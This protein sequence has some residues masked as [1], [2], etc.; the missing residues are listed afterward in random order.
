[1]MPEALLSIKNVVATFKLN[2]KIDVGKVHKAFKKESTCNK[3]VF[4]KKVVVLKV[5]R[6]RMSFLIY[7]T[8]SVVC[9]GAES[10]KDAK[11]S[12]N[13]LAKRF[14]KIGINVKL[15]TPVEIQNIVAS[16]NLDT[17]INLRKI[18]IENT[19]I[20][21]EPEQFPAAIWRM[22]NNVTILLFQSGKVICAGSKN[23]KDIVSAVETLKGKLIGE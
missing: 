5:E 17:K 6:P 11:E 18:A 15:L 21:Y 23:M 9:C 2:K 1:M 12:G 13:Y 7:G 14:R 16:A 20:E 3:N 22:P 8:G 4:R 10:V 19:E